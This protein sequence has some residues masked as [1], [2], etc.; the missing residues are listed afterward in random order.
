MAFQGFR[1]TASLF[2]TQYRLVNVTHW[3]TNKISKKRQPLSEFELMGEH[4][5]ICLIGDIPDWQDLAG[6]LAQLE[7]H[8]R[9]NGKTLPE[10][11][12]KVLDMLTDMRITDLELNK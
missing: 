8:A 7:I 3:F 9:Q 10:G 11:V 5:R 2:I 6:L 12:V 1:S 4:D